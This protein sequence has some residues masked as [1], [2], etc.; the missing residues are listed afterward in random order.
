MIYLNTWF[1]ILSL[2]FYFIFLR[3][4]LFLDEGREKKTERSISAFLPLLHPLLGTWPATQACALDWELN[5]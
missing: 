4:Y 3:L 2:L 5:W 1:V